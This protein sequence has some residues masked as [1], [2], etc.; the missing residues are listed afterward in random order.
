MLIYLSMLESDEDKSKFEIIYQTYKNLMFHVA[1]QVLGDTQDSEDVV[2]QSFIKI[3]ENIEKINEVKCPKTR[4]FIVTIVKRTAIDLY[5]KR[6]KSPFISLF[7]E[8]KSIISQEDII[9]ESTVVVR[10]IA[11]LS[12]KYRDILLLRYD[13][14]YS[15]NEVAQFMGMTTENVH[16]TLQ[17]AKAKLA[18]ILE[19]TEV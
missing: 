1:N 16:K 13:L 10:A 4:S 6:K 11:S 2:H 19:E 9:I 18:K 14:G 15:E 7:D 5:R 12:E 3:I 8:D 17:R